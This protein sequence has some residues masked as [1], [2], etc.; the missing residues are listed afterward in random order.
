MAWNVI[1]FIYLYLYYKII[2]G[3][4]YFF[5]LDPKPVFSCEI[6]YT[7]ICLF[8]FF[9]VFNGKRCFWVQMV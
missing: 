5:S 6:L 3:K 1:E 4:T 7:D 9:K 2:Y 8:N